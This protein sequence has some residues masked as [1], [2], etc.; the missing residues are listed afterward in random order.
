MRMVINGGNE[1][2]KF[3]RGRAGISVREEADPLLCY[4]W[5]K[6]Q[7]TKSTQSTFSN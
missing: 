7:S 3:I 4:C 6:Y 5:L 1:K 2:I